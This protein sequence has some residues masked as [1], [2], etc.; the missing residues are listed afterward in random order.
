M[1]S[2]NES[3]VFGLLLV[4]SFVS[5]FGLDFVC[6]LRYCTDDDSSVDS[7]FAGLGRGTDEEVDMNMLASPGSFRLA[8]PNNNSGGRSNS[9]NNRRTHRRYQSDPGPGVMGGLYLEGLG[10]P[11]TERADSGDEFDLA[12]SVLSPSNSFTNFSMPPPS[13]TRPGKLR[14]RVACVLSKNLNLP[15]LFVIYFY[16]LAL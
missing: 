13:S 15:C 9:T 10:A 8:G 7:C 6:A 12:H 14:R 5:L 11:F 4:S 3:I 2:T 16:A 1:C